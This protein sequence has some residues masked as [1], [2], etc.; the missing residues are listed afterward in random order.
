MRLHYVNDRDKIPAQK[1]WKYRGKRAKARHHF[2]HEIKKKTGEAKNAG[3]LFAGHR[4]EIC[5]RS[6]KIG[7]E[8]GLYSGGRKE[9]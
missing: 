8:Y 6:A 3:G 9:I 2:L 7:S 4:G 1:T 5:S